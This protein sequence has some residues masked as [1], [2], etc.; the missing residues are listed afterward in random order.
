LLF[1]IHSLYEWADPEVIARDE[2][3]Q[4]KHGY[5]NV[6]FFIIR[7]ALYFTSWLLLSYWLNRW[8]L[9]QDE[10][11][12]RTLVRKL[13]LLS[14]P[15]MIV[16]GLAITFASVDWV[17]SID[18]HWFSTIYGMLFIVG[19]S[20]AAFAFVI[21]V[22][23]FLSESRPIS[24]FLN[25]EVFQDLGNLL[26]AFVMLWAYISFSQYL[27]IWSG[28]LPEEIPWY[29]RRG[30]NGWQWVAAV[31][32]VFHFFL[33]FLLL[34]GRAN[35]RKKVFLTGIALTILVMRWLDLYWLVAP[36]F[37]P[38]PGIHWLDVLLCLVIGVVWGYA[39]FAQL[40]KRALLPTGDPSFVVEKPA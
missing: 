6:P 15:G 25:A 5:L 9:Q 37:L 7:A 32:A 22:A 34:L 3:I 18:P 20:L 17:M 40:T 10:T 35:K 1:G 28:N 23:A 26:L 14:G 24:H 4:A 11:R 29:L 31:L 38:S 2:V 30:T 8:S 19:Q 33:P 21:V 12:D 39:F 13:Q 16:Y 36:S 27:I